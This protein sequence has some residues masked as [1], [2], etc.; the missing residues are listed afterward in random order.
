MIVAFGYARK[1]PD[2]KLRTEVSISNQVTLIENTCK[3]RNWNLKEVYIDNNISGGDRDRKQ[4]NRLIKDCMAYRKA[5]AEDEV[6]IVVKEQDRFAR[7]SAFFSDT[8]RDLQIRGIRV[9]SIIK[10][11]FLSY[12]DLGDVVTSVVDAHYII[13]S[14]KKTQVLFEQKKQ[15]GMP[16]I[17]APFGY[18]NLNKRWVVDRR[19]A[20]IVLDVYNSKN[21]GENF[22]ETIARN[23][24]SV[25][26]YYRILENI[27]KGI[28]SGYIVYTNKI[29]DSQKR[30]VTEQEIKYL[31][32]HEPII[33]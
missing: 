30:I 18:K 24:I 3:E 15:E 1:S 21:K 13:A 22:R 7:D 9:F 17:K 32:K 19:K 25:D 8:L 11:N 6:Y 20:Q 16:P 29:R 27:K 33:N 14:R 12:D 28:Y 31:G 4:M 26:V 23:K 10:N 2:D 5:H